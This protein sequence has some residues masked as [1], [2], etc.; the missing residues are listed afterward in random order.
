MADTLFE[1]KQGCLVVDTVT[2]DVAEVM[3]VFDARV[4]LRPPNG[5]IE[6]DRPKDLV[7][8]ATLS[9]RLRPRLTQV[10]RESRR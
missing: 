2:G 6:W 10:N 9:D 5:G 7:R 3:E 8:E 1:P 4:V